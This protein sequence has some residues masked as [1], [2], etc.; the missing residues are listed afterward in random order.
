MGKRDIRTLLIPLN[1]IDEFGGSLRG[2][3]RLQK[4]IFLSQK[5]FD[6]DFDFN[7]EKAPLGPLSYDL[8]YTVDEL[9]DLGLIER[10]QDKTDFGFRVFKYKITSE[11]KKFL[12]FGKDKSLISKKTIQ[13]NKNT[14]EEYGNK[15]H[16]QLLDYVH[17]EYPKFQVKS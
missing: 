6:G 8:L 1:L 11:G 9:N 10:E 15:N 17:K 14:V 13:A 12:D 4:L 2:K 5:E 16:I 7:F 3:T